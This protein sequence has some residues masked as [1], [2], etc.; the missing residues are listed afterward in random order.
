MAWQEIDLATKRFACAPFGGPIA[1]LRD[2]R[3]AVVIKGPCLD[4]VVRLFTA[5]G[6]QTGSFS[7]DGGAPALMAW[8]PREEL[9]MLRKNGRASFYDVH[10]T[11]LPRELSIGTEPWHLCIQLHPLTG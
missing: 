1:A 2:D 3:K 6:A 10:G 8:T 7:W 4:P 11:R 9:L 5:A